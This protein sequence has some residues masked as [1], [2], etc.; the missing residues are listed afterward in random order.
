MTES[1]RPEEAD[2]RFWEALASGQLE[3]QRCSQCGI[4]HWPAVFCCGAC[5]SWDQEWV[6]VPIEGTIF[7][8]TRTHHDFPGTEGLVKPFVTVVV[9]IVD[10]QV[11]LMGLLEGAQDGVSIGAKVTGRVVANPGE[12]RGGPSFRWRLSG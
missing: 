2:A 9:T 8:W 4:W 7:T 5:G 11:Q 1:K 6:P 3:L 12:A 10:S